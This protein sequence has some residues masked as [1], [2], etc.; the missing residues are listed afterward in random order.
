MVNPAVVGRL[1]GSLRSE[2][3]LGGG[4]AKGIWPI[5]NAVF[6]LRR[7]QYPVGNLSG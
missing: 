3:S 1:W 6:V 7:A 2:A 5:S 4:L